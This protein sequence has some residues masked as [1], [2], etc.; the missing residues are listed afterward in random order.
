MIEELRYVDGTICCVYDRLGIIG[1]EIG[2]CFFD[3]TL[4]GIKD[5]TIRDGIAV[6]VV[7]ISWVDGWDCG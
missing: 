6:R 4:V 2:C 5:V 1:G 3:G 7:C